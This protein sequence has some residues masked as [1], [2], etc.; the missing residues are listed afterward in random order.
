MLVVDGLE[1]RYGDA[2]AIRDVS[3]EVPD[4]AITSILG[5]NGAGKSTLLRAIA[6]HLSSSGGRIVFDGED[7]TGLPPYL[8]A[9]RGIAV[10]PEGRRMFSHLTVEENLLVGASA[11][12]S[13]SGKRKRLGEMYDLFPRLSERKQQQAGTLSGGEQQMV[14]IARAMML[15]PKLVLFDEPSLG[16]API[17]TDLVFETI[18]TLGQEGLTMLLVEQ[19]ASL[20]LATASRGY[21]LEQG[22]VVVEGDAATLQASPAVREAYLGMGI[23]GEAG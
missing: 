15:N 17:V 16:L 8:I 10:V 23:E 1:V 13:Q 21:V 14:A 4:H 6:G 2:R 19:N 11:R 5:S 7:I 9:E 18:S 20:A 12:R 22:R 3:I